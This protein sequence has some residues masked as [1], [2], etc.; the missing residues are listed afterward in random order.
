MGVTQ[1][2]LD[3]T[4]GTRSSKKVVSDSDQSGKFSDNRIESFA[5]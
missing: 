4:I 1:S 3:I 2:Y 5:T